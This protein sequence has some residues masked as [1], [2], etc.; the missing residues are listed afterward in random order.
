MDLSRESRLLFVY[1][2]TNQYI[3]ISGVFEL[4][5][6]VIMFE[7]G[8][9]ETQL[10]QGKSDLA[11]K[12]LF[13]DGWVRVFNVDQ[14]NSYRNSP[15]NEIAYKRE[16]ESAPPQ[17]V[18]TSIDTSIHT[19]INHKS[20]IINH[21]EGGVGETNK[22][23]TPQSVSDEKLQK[24]IAEQYSVALKVVSD[25]AEELILYCKSKGKR[26]SDYKATL[27]N[28]VRR[29][30]KDDPSI[31]KNKES[32]SLAEVSRIIRERSNL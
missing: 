25:T 1:L 16:I 18:D 3:N 14:Y 27:Q 21:K 11:G 6:R 2:L 12:V 5:D 8:L 32:D 7:T 30:I 4:P 28:W 31:I 17:V 29:R 26:Y 10:E 20:E 13:K 15:K 24:E 23:K 22:Y 9:T 19:P